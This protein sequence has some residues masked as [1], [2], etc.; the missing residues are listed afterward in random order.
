MS[1]LLLLS[2]IAQKLWFIHKVT[3]NLCM[4]PITTPPGGLFS[5]IWPCNLK[6]AKSEQT[7]IVVEVTSVCDLCGKFEV[8][9]FNVKVTL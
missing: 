3:F 2:P 9:S 6:M 5:Y 7:D 4:R 1:F 8:C